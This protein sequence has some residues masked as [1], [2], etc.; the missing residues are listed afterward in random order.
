MNL[1]DL[2]IDLPTIFFINAMFL[3][4]CLTEK[5]MMMQ[6]I[7]ATKTDFPVIV[8][9]THWKWFLMQLRLRY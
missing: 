8:E 7:N 1:E 3:L 9:I 6:S 4:H 2:L 5:R